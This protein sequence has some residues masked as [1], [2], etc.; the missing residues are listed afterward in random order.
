MQVLSSSFFSHPNF[1]FLRFESLKVFCT[2]ISSPGPTDSA[3]RSSK[4]PIVWYNFEGIIE[5]APIIAGSFT[6]QPALFPLMELLEDDTPKSIE[7]VTKRAM[8]F[9][10]L[11]YSSVNIFLSQFDKEFL[12]F[13]SLSG[14]CLWLPHVRRK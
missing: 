5:V 14:R 2:Y 10:A 3:L 13:V 6:C 1:Q 11:L 7:F 9:V 8:A 4:Y 12:V